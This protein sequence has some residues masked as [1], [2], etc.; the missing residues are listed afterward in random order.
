MPEKLTLSVWPTPLEPVPRLAVAL[1]LGAG[2]L[3]LKRD[4]L[5]GLGGGGNKVRKLEWLVAD[6]LSRGADTL[7]TTGGPQSNHAR[8]TA[9][10]GARAGLDVV[11]V[12]PGPADAHP[13]AGNLVLDA[14][15]GARVTW[16]DGAAGAADLTAAAEETCAALA[17]SGA[18]P[19]LVPFGGSSALGARGYQE[20]GREVLAQL[21]DV[22]HM[23]TALGSGGTMA[24]LV[25]ALGPERVLGVDVGALPDPAATAAG[26][27]GELTG[28]E[29]PAGALRVRRDQV[30]RGY[31]TLHPPVLDAVRLVA[32]S[33]GVVLD[34]VYTGRAAAGLFAAV[35][36]GDIRPG[37][38][39]VLLHSG[40][41]P[42][43]LG[44]AETV[45]RAGEALA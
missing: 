36:E 7:V 22:R 25:T 32:A 33:E 20:A 40:G 35:R 16:V 42:G 24:G 43:L 4:D 28:H 5:T 3:Y 30:G 41:L 11:L 2:D 12:L 44:H 38:P 10:A 1:G 29:L 31:A 14:L 34:P 8:L 17:G 37:E 15:L 18:R 23:V 27:V 13:V 39:T 45:R 9:A 6:A 19:Y 21:P 26:F